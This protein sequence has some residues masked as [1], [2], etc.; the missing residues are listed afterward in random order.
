MV[1]VS[2]CFSHRVIYE[3]KTCKIK[4]YG[5][6]THPCDLNS[7]WRKELQIRLKKAAKESPHLQA[8]ELYEKEI[9]GMVD[10]VALMLYT[11]LLKHTY[12]K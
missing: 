3:I 4:Q 8:K 11:Y 9:K 12:P 6:H 5:N 1:N 2:V 10:E 7:I